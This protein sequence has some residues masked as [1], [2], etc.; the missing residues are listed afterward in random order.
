MKIWFKWNCEVIKG[1]YDGYCSGNENEEEIYNEIYYRKHNVTEDEYYTLIWI[2]NQ[3]KEMF[4]I[5]LFFNSTKFIIENKDFNTGLTSGYCDASIHGLRHEIMT[6][7]IEI[8]NLIIKKDEIKV[9]KNRILSGG[10]NDGL[11]WFL[12]PIIDKNDAVNEWLENILPMELIDI[13]L[14]YMWN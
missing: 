14:I 10:Y 5:P 7:P 11:S 8:L 12:K 4:N 2:N 3:C 6:T 13:I 9:R 1:N